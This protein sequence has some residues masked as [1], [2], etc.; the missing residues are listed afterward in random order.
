M[1]SIQ[2]IGHLMLDAMAYK[3]A[4]ACKQEMPCKQGMQPLALLLKT[5]IPC[6]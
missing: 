3:Q 6:S 4:M 5:Q 1:A 2:A